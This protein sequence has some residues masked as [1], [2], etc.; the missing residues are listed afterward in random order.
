MIALPFKEGRTR[1]RKGF[2][3]R[4]IACQWTTGKGF[5]PR[6]TY[7]PLLGQHVIADQV[8]TDDLDMEIRDGGKK[9]PVAIELLHA[10]ASCR[11]LD[12]QGPML[13]VKG[14]EILHIVGI[15]GR[16]VVPKCLHHESSPA[17]DDPPGVTHPMNTS[18][19]PATGVNRPSPNLVKAFITVPL[20]SLRL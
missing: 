14:H 8:C 2:A 11:H 7:H 19:A 18:R 16:L 9:T 4:F 1:N 6:T 3:S 12:V 10:A 20:R 13:P 5:L 15:L 17:V